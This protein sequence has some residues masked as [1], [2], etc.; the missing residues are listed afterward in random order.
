MNSAAC[1]IVVDF[2][3]LSKSVSVLLKVF[4]MLK[5]LLKL[6]NVFKMLT[7]LSNPVDNL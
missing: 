3:S 4:N 1:K 7:T 2:W 5:V 6:L